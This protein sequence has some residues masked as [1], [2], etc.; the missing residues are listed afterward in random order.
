MSQKYIVFKRFMYYEYYIWKK[1]NMQTNIFL[2]S[3]YNVFFYF[4]K[5]ADLPLCMLTRW[6]RPLSQSHPWSPG[7]LCLPLALALQSKTWTWSETTACWFL[8][9]QPVNSSW[10]WSR[11][12]IPRK[13]TLYR[14]LWQKTLFEC[15]FLSFHLLLNVLAGLLAISHVTCFFSILLWSF[16]ICLDRESLERF[17][18]TA[19][20]YSTQKHTNIDNTWNIHLVTSTLIHILFL[21]INLLYPYIFTLPSSPPGPVPSKP[22]N[23]AW[24]TN[25]VCWSSWF[26]LRSTPRCPTVCTR[27]MGYF[28]QAPKM[29]PPQRTRAVIP[30]HA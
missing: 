2:F 29:G 15:F 28:Y 20:T 1:K 26:H 13:H 27:R 5:Q 8:E 25:A 9:Q 30:P 23:Q 3:F 21:C 16:C 10:S 12:P 14:S 18:F 11:W 4:L 17:V 6:C 7:C 22:R 24:Q 19:S